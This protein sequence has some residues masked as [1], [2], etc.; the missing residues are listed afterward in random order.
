MIGALTPLQLLNTRSTLKAITDAS[1]KLIALNPSV[2]SP[3]SMSQTYLEGPAEF[4]FNLNLQK[5]FS[6]P[7]GRELV[8]EGTAFNV[9]NSP[10]FGL[11]NTNINSTTFGRI[12]TAG[13]NRTVQLSG[14]INF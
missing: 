12:T 13:G 10:M 7:N 9:L 14:R 8:L 5:S 6:L 4:E 2:G 11:P 3:G 1:G